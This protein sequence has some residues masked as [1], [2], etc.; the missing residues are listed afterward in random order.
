MRQCNEKSAL[1]L[2][3]K[4]TSLP[5]FFKLF[6][7]ITANEATPFEA[8]PQANQTRF[9]QKDSHERINL[10]LFHKRL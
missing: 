3:V 4:A 6:M 7:G 5:R 1:P 9:Q 8:K 10:A 2:V